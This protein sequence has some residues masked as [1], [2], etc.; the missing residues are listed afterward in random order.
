MAVTDLLLNKT[1]NYAQ[2]GVQ[3]LFVSKD[4]K[5]QTDTAM[6]GT[7]GCPPTVSWLCHLYKKDKV[8]YMQLCNKSL[9]Y[10][11]EECQRL[12][13]KQNRKSSALSAW[14]L[15]TEVDLEKNVSCIF[16]K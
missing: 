11:H 8:I 14:N 15:I 9:Q 3:S 12:S 16:C 2:K 5:T 7:S 6:S 1:L 13:K 10:V 4:K